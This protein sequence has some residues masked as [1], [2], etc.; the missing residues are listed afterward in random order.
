[1]APDLKGQH[2]RT[3][4]PGV[5]QGIGGHEAHGLRFPLHEGD[6]DEHVRLRTP[7]GTGEDETGELVLDDLPRVGDAA[8]LYQVSVGFFHGV[9]ANAHGHKDAHGEHAEQGHG[10]ED[11]DERDARARIFGSCG[12]VGLVH[13]FSGRGMRAGR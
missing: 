6:G 11:F 2:L 12:E 5:L 9:E 7:V 10:D 1:M 13:W 3:S 8:I 4:A